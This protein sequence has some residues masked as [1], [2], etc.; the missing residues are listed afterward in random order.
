MHS[1]RLFAA[2]IVTHTA[3]G[4]MAWLNGWIAGR[5]FERRGRDQDWR[6]PVPMCDLDD[7]AEPLPA[8]NWATTDSGLTS[9]TGDQRNTLERLQTTIR[10]LDDALAQ[11]PAR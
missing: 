6:E 5:V 9:P 3:I 8:Y 4:A 1:T 2:L 10:R 11:K 7:L